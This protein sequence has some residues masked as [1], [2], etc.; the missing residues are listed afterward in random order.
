M[1]TSM[2]EQLRTLIAGSLSRSEHTSSTTMQADANLEDEYDYLPSDEAT[3][4]SD[5]ISEQELDDLLS[6]DSDT[7]GKVTPAT[8]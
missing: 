4:L 8:M 6:D 3:N 2:E 1:G 5:D 7:D